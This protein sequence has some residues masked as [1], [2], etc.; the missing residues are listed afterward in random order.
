MIVKIDIACTYCNDNGQCQ[1]TNMVMESKTAMLNFLL[2]ILLALPILLLDR[3]GSPTER[4]FFIDDDSLSYPYKIDTVP[5]WLLYM[6][7]FGTPMVLIL[8][9]NLS[10]MRSSS[11]ENIFESLKHSYTM[12]ILYLLGKCLKS[13]NE[14]YLHFCSKTTSYVIPSDSL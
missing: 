5:N 2:L 14:I 6:M 7:G 8:L 9:G 10:I 12:I 11:R 1:V 3:I 13:Y 4:G